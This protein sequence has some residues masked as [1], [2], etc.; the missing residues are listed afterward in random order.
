MST[1]TNRL[2]QVI[3]PG[4]KV[5]AIAQGYSNAIKE[6]AGTFVGLSAGGSPQVRI[7]VQIQQWL[8]PDDAIGKWCSG[9]KFLGPVEVERVSTYCAGRVYK[10]A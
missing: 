4:D 1:F 7:K 2:G 8:T 9:A 10:L 5:I 6:R 3:S